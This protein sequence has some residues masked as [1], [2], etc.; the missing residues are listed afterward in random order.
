VAGAWSYHDIWDGWFGAFGLGRT[1]DAGASW[2][3]IDFCSVSFG[4]RPIGSSRFAC[5]GQH[6]WHPG[7]RAPNGNSLRSTD[8]GTTWLDMDTL[9]SVRDGQEPFDISFIDTLHG[10]AIDPRTNI[11]GTT[12]GGDS[13]TIIAPGL[14]VKR[15]EMT[16]LTDGWAISDSEL[17]HT[18]DGGANWVSVM[19]Q[20]G[21]EAIGFCDPRHGAIVGLNVLLLR[22]DDGG[23]TW[24]RDSSEFTSDLYAVCV[25]DSEHMWASGENGLVL[26]FGDWASDVQDPEF[27]SPAVGHG[28]RLTVRPNPCRDYVALALSRPAAANLH[29][30]LLDA[31]GRVVRQIE[32]PSGERSVSLDLRALPAGVYF[33]GQTGLPA[34]SSVRLVKLR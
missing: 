9:G 29:L 13:W 4:E 18:T 30:R 28:S 17:F 10:W 33:V 1:A 11:R 3:T 15:L 20:T 24:T 32:V 6:I 12:N 25:L 27:S 8:G 31:S 5:V 26:G 19:T 21:L 22:T 14:N 23:E 7:V 34:T 16:T 2:D